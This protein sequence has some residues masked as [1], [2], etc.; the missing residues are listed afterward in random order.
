MRKIK[1][2]YNENKNETKTKHLKDNNE[3]NQKR[4]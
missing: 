3:K 2:D 4:L 1:N